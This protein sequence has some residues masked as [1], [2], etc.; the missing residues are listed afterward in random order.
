MPPFKKPNSST[1]KKFSTDKVIPFSSIVYVQVGNEDLDD[2]DKN[3]PER[4]K[5][6]SALPESIYIS[7]GDLSTRI[8]LS[9]ADVASEYGHYLKGLLA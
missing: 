8:R 5:T 4:R 1:N 6:L 9:S 2:L 7:A 3:K